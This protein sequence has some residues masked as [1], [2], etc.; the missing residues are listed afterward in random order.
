MD[1]QPEHT[2]A[3]LLDSTWALWKKWS[4]P[5]GRI[6]GI[7]IRIHGIVLLGLLVEYKNLH[8]LKNS[9]YLFA[10]LLFYSGL[11]LSILLHEMGH[12]LTAKF[13]GNTVKGI[14]VFP[15]FGGIAFI[16]LDNEKPLRNILIY[17][18]GPVVN[19]ILALILLYL[20]KYANMKNHF[21]LADELKL[22]MNV[23]LLIGFANLIPFYPLDGGRI[24]QNVILLLKSG[25]RKAN[26]ITLCVSCAC[27]IAI[28]RYKLNDGDYV[29]LT[30]AT[31][32]MIISFLV[33]ME[34]PAVYQQT[35]DKVSLDPTFDTK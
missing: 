11:F 26:I 34:K 21:L 8:Y 14:I 13:F 33:L 17:M 12:A 10:F 24:L 18:A 7:D 9:S 30:I 5:F 28:T 2:L 19:I 1:T 6:L 20:Y 29:G 31:L 15:P 25:E 32:L 27:F 16:A 3:E 4:I 23:N 35:S 22:I